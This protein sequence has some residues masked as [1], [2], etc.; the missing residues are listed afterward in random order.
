MLV[1]EMNLEMMHLLAQAAESEAA[2]LDDAGVDR[3]DGHLVHLLAL[4]LV[5]GIAVASHRA[6]MLEADRLEPGVPG[7]TDAM[8]LVKLALEAVHEGMRGRERVIAAVRVEARAQYGE[9]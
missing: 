7:N 8:L 1:A 2:R 4:D 6:R 3:A 5:E 9:L